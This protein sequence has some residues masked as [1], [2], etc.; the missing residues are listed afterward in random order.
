MSDQDDSSTSQIDDG[1][2]VEAF[3]ADPAVKRAIQRVNDNIFTEFKSATTTVAMEGVWAKSKALDLLADELVRVMSN[4]Q[5]AQHTRDQQEQRQ[6][7]AKR[8][9]G[10]K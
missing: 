7:A 8:F 5:I 9:N 4:G 2:R 10:R 3:L 1:R 6:H